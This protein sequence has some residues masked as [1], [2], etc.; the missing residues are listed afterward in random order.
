M[1]E[2]LRVVAPVLNK[3]QANPFSYEVREAV[4]IILIADWDIDVPNVKV[5]QPNMAFLYFLALS[6]ALAKYIVVSQQQIELMILRDQEINR[7][8]EL[9]FIVSACAE[10]VTNLT[11]LN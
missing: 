7:L 3:H 11:P 8:L 1:Y 5:V 4:R 10:Q 2:L 6:R 9:I